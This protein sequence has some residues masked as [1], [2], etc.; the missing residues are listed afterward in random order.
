MQHVQLTPSMDKLFNGSQ[1]ISKISLT[2]LQPNR[3]LSSVLPVT[4]YS[5]RYSGNFWTISS[6]F[7][8]IFFSFSSFFFFFLTYLV[9]QCLYIYECYNNQ[10]ERLKL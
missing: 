4:K 10:L 6:Y 8:T 9:L 1:A 5:T 7:R 3:T 2:A